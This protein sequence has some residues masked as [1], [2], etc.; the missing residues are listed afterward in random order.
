MVVEP[1]TVE[2]ARGVEAIK[3]VR[4]VAQR[5]VTAR[6]L[7]LGLVWRQHHV[8]VARRRV[9]LLVGAQIKRFGTRAVDANAVARVRDVVAERQRAQIVAATLLISLTAASQ[10]RERVALAR[11]AGRDVAKHFRARAT[12]TVTMRRVA[13]LAALV[14]ARVVAHGRVGVAVVYVALLAGNLSGSQ[15]RTVLLRE[16]AHAL[17]TVCLKTLVR[18]V[19]GTLR[20]GHA[21][22]R[23][24][25]R[26]LAR[27]LGTR[28]RRRLRRRLRR[29]F[30]R[31]FA[32][33]F[34]RRLHTRFRTRFE[35]WFG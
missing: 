14:V 9:T 28:F 26:W 8:T 11:H 16:A 20:V 3:V 33:R 29:R 13:D 22:Q 19:R 2:L 25:R 18:W 24:L 32:R 6:A 15:R 34:G 12:R 31:R 23:R 30:A 1:H 5:D 27:R 35:C 10:I 17:C 7:T 21:L 4:V